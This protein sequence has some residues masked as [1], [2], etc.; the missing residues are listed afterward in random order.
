MLPQPR[1]PRVLQINATLQS[2]V[3]VWTRA[4]RF[5]LGGQKW[6]FS[7]PFSK[8]QMQSN[9]QL[10]IYINFY[11]KLIHDSIKQAANMGQNFRLINKYFN[12]PS[13]HSNQLD[14]IHNAPWLPLAFYSCF[15][16]KLL[17]DWSV[18]SQEGS[19]LVYPTV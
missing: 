3:I 14:L 6:F 7:V 5:V 16:A 19:C 17:Y 18:H 12:R 2:R 8:H 11:T 1:N 13:N 10:Q 15:A 4:I 9:Q